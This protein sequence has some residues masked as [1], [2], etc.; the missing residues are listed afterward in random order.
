MPNDKY[1][2][3][4]TLTDEIINLIAEISELVGAVTVKS[5]M[6]SSPRLRRENRIR[7]IH[8]SLAIENNT[9]SLDNV[10]DIIN[11]K[12]V[13]GAPGEIREVKNTYEA[14][15]LLLG[16]DPYSIND[17]LKAH[18]V[19][20]TDLTKEAGCFRSG[21][22]GV[23]AGEQL[24]HMAPPAELV[25]KLTA[26]LMSW[27]KQEKVHPLIKSCVFHYE[28]EFI[29][30]FADGN[31]RMGR[32]WQT[33]LLYQ[34]KQ[35]FAW[36]PVETII[37]ERQQEYYDV[38][39]AADRNSDSGVFIAFLLRAIFDTLKEL[40]ET[41]QG[42]V[43]VT[44]QVEKLMTVLRDGEWSGKE[45]MIHLGLKHRPTFLKNYLQPAI[46]LGLVEMTFP[47][48]PNSKKQKYRLV[49]K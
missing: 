42:R 2:P 20:M 39:A 15:N 36:L 10:T 12:R 17:M 8:A 1:T 32:M 40:E 14:Y 7:T 33:L 21:G 25:P 28:F 41:E 31:G 49:K 43:Q 30:P 16:Y 48:T 24:V 18:K 6:E 38:L 44:E 47:E 23:F 45:L 4:Y 46:A 11:G 29:H 22:V 37:K 19:L 3:P 13:L 5:S 26:E 27:A 35:L 9:L 34:W